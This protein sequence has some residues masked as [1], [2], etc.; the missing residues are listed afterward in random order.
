MVTEAAYLIRITCETGIQD[1]SPYFEHL[2]KA[3][4]HLRKLTPHCDKCSIDLILEVREY[5]SCGSHD[6]TTHWKFLSQTP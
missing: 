4:A 2:S 6:N 1:E 3:K 5:N